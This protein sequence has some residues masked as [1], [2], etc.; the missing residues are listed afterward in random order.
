MIN[1]RMHAWSKALVHDDDRT[2]TVSWIRS[3]QQGLHS[4]TVAYTG[5]AVRIGTRLGTRPGFWGMSHHV[6]VRM[7]IEHAV[8]R[9]HEPVRGRRIEV[10]SEPV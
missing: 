7:I 6:V 9:L 2:M 5:D 8:I 3:V 4:V 1:P 10:M